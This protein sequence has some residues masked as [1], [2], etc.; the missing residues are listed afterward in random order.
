MANRIVTYRNRVN[1]EIGVYPEELAEHFPNLEEVAD[2][3]KPLAYVPITQAEIDAVVGVTEDIEID[4]EP[5]VILDIDE[6]PEDFEPIFDAV[7]TKD[8]F[9]PEYQPESGEEGNR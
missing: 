2:D 1:G 8:D 9:T 6:E 5:A 3:A 7:A 4:E